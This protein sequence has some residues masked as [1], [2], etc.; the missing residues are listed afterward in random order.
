MASL[1]NELRSVF[2]AISLPSDWT[3][4]LPPIWLVRDWKTLLS[5]MEARAAE[6]V[7]VAYSEYREARPESVATALIREAMSL[8][9]A[10]PLMRDSRSCV[11]P[12]EAVARSRRG[13]KKRILA[14]GCLLVL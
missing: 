4:E 12:V 10:K 14:V 6:S 8:L 5:V 1:T 11:R 3:A 9:V 13:V 2:V 7:T